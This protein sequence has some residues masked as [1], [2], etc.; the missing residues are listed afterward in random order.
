MGT[1]FNIG[2]KWVVILGIIIMVF[3]SG[4]FGLLSHK[5]NKT[6]DQLL[7]QKN[8]TEALRDSIN[9]TINKY[10]EVVSE[11]RTL[12]ADLKTLTKQNLNLS[13]NQR[14]LIDRIKNI[15]KDNEVISAALIKTEAKL[16]SALYAN[17]KVDVNERDSSILFTETNDSISFRLRVNKALPVSPLVKPTLMFEDLTIPNKQFIEFHWENDKRYEQK[18]VSFSVSNSN[19]IFETYDLDSYTIPEINKEAIKPTGWEKMKFFMKDRKS[20][21]IIGAITGGIGIYIGA[22]QF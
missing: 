16:D 8:L 11:K 6:H 3:F 18:P 12:Q 7:Q 4:G 2:L 5:L 9:T 22:T 20:E 17:A 21:L 19:P 10:G 14:E 15:Q 1:N 13:S